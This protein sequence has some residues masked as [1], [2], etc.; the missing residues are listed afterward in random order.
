MVT[1]LSLEIITYLNNFKRLF[2]NPMQANQETFEMWYQCQ[3]RY[4][5]FQW[6]DAHALGLRVG[7]LSGK[8]RDYRPPDVE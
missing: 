2:Y 8:R 5:K 3:L 7:R 4:S 1:Y 6:A